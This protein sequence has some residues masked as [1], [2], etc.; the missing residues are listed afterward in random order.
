MSSQTWRVDPDRNRVKDEIKRLFD[1]NVLGKEPSVLAGKLK[2]DGHEG[3][4]LQEQFG[5]VADNKNAPD[6]DGFE[7]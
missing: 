1:L 5:L 3:H 4:W 6:F 7:L 2:H